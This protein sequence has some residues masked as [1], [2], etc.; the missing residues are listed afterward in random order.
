MSRKTLKGR[1]TTRTQAPARKKMERPPPGEIIFDGKM[2][3]G[4]P[5][6][7]FKAWLDERRRLGLPT[8]P[9]RTRG[10]PMELCSVRGGHVMIEP[11]K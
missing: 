9:I 2:A 11:E 6:P 1:G 7:T 10:L 3:D 8:G 4:T 5:A